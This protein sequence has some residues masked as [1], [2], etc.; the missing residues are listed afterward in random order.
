MTII[1]VYATYINIHADTCRGN[2]NIWYIVLMHY[3]VTDDYHS[4]I[5]TY[6]LASDKSLFY[7]QLMHLLQTSGESLLC[8]LR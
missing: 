1:Y 3:S 7:L 2:P 5:Y 6:M 4:E 8:M